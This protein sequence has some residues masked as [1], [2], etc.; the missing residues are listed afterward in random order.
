MSLDTYAAINESVNAETERER[1]QFA[2]GTNQA[3]E[4]NQDAETI[5]S[6]DILQALHRNEDGDADLFIKK[7][8]GRLVY[9]HAA[10]QWFTWAGHHWEADTTEE[11]LAGV[12]F[13]ANQNLPISANIN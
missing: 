13:D 8:R 5:P 9:D 4:P 7:H 3:K 1:K 11:A 12:A 10:G 2:P 6:A